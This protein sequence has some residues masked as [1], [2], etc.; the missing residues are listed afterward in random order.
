MTPTT[1]G[2]FD[3]VQLNRHVI[4]TIGERSSLPRLSLPTA[5]TSSFDSQFVCPLCLLSELRDNRDADC[6]Q[7]VELFVGRSDSVSDGATK[8]VSGAGIR[9]SIAVR[10]VTPGSFDR[11]G[12]A[13]TVGGKP[14]NGGC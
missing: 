8:E 10:E 11:K 14:T 6:G 9:H 3:E 1:R 7:R 2:Q 13:Y 4:A 12:S 5:S